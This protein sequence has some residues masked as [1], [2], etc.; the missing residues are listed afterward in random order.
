[1][2]RLA[3]PAMRARGVA[4]LLTVAFLVLAAWAAA[5]P[6][7]TEALRLQQIGRFDAP[8]YV[9]SAPGEPGRLY[10]VEQSGRIRVLAKGRVKTFLDIHRKLVSGGEQGLLS[11]AC[12]PQYQRNH[13]FYVNFTDPDTR[14][15]RFRSR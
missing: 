10:V 1:A 9:A 2:R 15:V 13:F 6:R 8:T 5:S 4:A 12:D 14:V 3:F 7:K 11:M